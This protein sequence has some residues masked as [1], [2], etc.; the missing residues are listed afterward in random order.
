MSDPI[1]LPP[2][3]STKFES[4]NDFIQCVQHGGEV[5]FVYHDRAYSITHIDQDTIDI[6]E[7]YYLKDGVAYNVNN[8]K[9]CISMIGEQYHIAEEVLEYVI[10]GV[11]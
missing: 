2:D 6:G 8:H 7:G 5:E 10:D 1:I 3:Y 9:E 4:I 11:K